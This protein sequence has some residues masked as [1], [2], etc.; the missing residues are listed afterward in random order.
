[1]FGLTEICIIQLSIQKIRIFSF[2]ARHTNIT[3]IRIDKTA[4]REA[5][6]K[7]IERE[8]REMEAHAQSETGGEAEPVREPI[9][10]EQGSSEGLPE[11]KTTGGGG[12]QQVAGSQEKAE[13]A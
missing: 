7:E 3:H 8:E 9:H 10:G 5:Q 1:M 2:D 11:S 12:V 13:V 4:V 6:R